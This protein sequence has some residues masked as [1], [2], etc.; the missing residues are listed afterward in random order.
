MPGW[1]AIGLLLCSCSI[2]CVALAGTMPP[3]DIATTTSIVNSELLDAILP[4]FR[5]ESEI[6]VRVH[7]AGSGRS[8]EMLS[9]ESNGCGVSMILVGL[10]L[11]SRRSPARRTDRCASWL[12]GSTFKQP[13]AEAN[14]LDIVN[15]GIAGA[16]TR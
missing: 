5:T 16:R 4:A 11:R 7:A 12:T 1:R 6:V 15:N 13:Q 3:L 10:W 9:A 14:I 2:G 8:L